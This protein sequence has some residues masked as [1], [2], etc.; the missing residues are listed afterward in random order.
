MLQ[1]EYFVKTWNFCID[2]FFH[3]N[4]VKGTFITFFLRWCYVLPQWQQTFSSIKKIGKDLGHLTACINCHD[5]FDVRKRIFKKLL[6]EIEW[7][8]I[9][10]VCSKS[11]KKVCGAF[12]Q[13][14]KE[15]ESPPAWTQE[16]Y[17]LP[18]SEHSFCCPNWVPPQ[19]GTPH[20]DLRPPG[21]V[22][23]LR[24]DLVGYPPRCLPH[25]ILGNVAKHYGI[26][27][28]PPR[29]GQTNKVKLLPS[30]HTTYAGG[31]YMHLLFYNHMQNNV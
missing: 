14:Q 5:F 21:R 26:W 23:P 11:L 16:A 22:P 2:M 29:C 25:G 27:V 18:C 31:K 28:P 20:P 6:R 8:S 12:E 3:V 13:T 10:P 30:R 9:V 15:Q 4:N 19:Q 1:K 17:R 7:K 24:L